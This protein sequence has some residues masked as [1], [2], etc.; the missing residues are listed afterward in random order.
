MNIKAEEERVTVL[1]H[2]VHQK[3]HEVVTLVES[4][5]LE[6]I[7]EVRIEI[8]KLLK[9]VEDFQKKIIATQFM[10]HYLAWLETSHR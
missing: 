5:I 10:E 9:I 4:D 8:D 7:K 6:H 3:V 1:I 2:P